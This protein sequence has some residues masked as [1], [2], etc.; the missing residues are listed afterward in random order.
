MKSAKGRWSKICRY[1]C[2]VCHAVA[3]ESQSRD[4]ILAC[5][6][7]CQNRIQPW[8]RYTHET[9]KWEKR[10]ASQDE[11][12]QS[13]CK[14]TFTWHWP[15]SDSGT[16]ILR[17]TGYKKHRNSTVWTRPGDDFILEAGEYAPSATWQMPV[18]SHTYSAIRKVDFWL[19]GVHMCTARDV[20]FKGKRPNEGMWVRR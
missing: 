19:D 7:L 6:L 17:C 14:F 5:K 16:R 11:C 1:Q 3:E 15:H 20:T 18:T 13:L 12:I 4:K 8:T 2:V 9:A 10:D